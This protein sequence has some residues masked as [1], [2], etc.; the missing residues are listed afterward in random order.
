ME[1]SFLLS[2]LS[3]PIYVAQCMEMSVRYDWVARKFITSLCSGKAV[4]SHVEDQITFKYRPIV[5]SQISQYMRHVRKENKHLH[6]FNMYPKQSA[7][8]YYELT[9]NIET[10][11][12]FLIVHV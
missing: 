6:T 2:L 10:K 1:T 5:H 11:Y 7:Y 9:C 4:S 12:I 8:L 3:F